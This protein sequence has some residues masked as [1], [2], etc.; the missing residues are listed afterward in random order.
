MTLKEKLETI[1]G[2]KIAIWCEEEDEAN[3]IVK[4]YEGDSF[5]YTYWG[6][7]KNKTCYDLED[8]NHYF[9]HADTDWYLENG[10]DL[11][12]YKKFIEDISKDKVVITNQN[13]TDLLNEKYGKDNW[14]IK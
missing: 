13:I 7:Y 12:T 11:V 10:F 8:K 6:M 9:T 4:A 1:K 2:K 14:V 3:V 5:T